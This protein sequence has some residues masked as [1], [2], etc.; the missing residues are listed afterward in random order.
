MQ[1]IVPVQH[2]ANLPVSVGHTIFE[3]GAISLTLDFLGTILAFR[4]HPGDR[5]CG[6][7]VPEPILIDVWIAF[8]GIS[9]MKS[10]A[11]RSHLIE[12]NERGMGVVSS[13]T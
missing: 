6:E 5:L 8:L 13:E 10:T 11:C 12:C 1:D 9:D 7:R 4:Q 3:R 2:R